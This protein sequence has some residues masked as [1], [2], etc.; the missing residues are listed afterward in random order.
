MYES[1]ETSVFAFPKLSDLNYGSWKTDMK[2]LLM[3]K[4]AGSLFL[5]LRNL[6]LKEHPI[7][8]SWRMNLESKA[9][10]RKPEENRQKQKNTTTISYGSGTV[11]DP[12]VRRNRKSSSNF[13]KYC[14]RK[15]RSEDGCF[16]KKEWQD[17][18]FCTENPGSNRLAAMK[19]FES[20]NV[21]TVVTRERPVEFLIGSAATTHICN[22][23]DWFSNLKEVY[24][25]EVLVGERDSSAKAVGIGD[26][27]FTILDIKGKVEINSK[28]VFYVPK[29][30]QNLICGAQIDIVELGILVG[31][32]LR[33]KGYRIFLP[34]EN[35][36]IETI[37]VYVDETKKGVRS[38][39]GK[40][41]QYEYAK[42]NLNSVNEFEDLDDSNHA[43]LLDKLSPFDIANWTR[44]EY[45]KTRSKRMHVYYCPP[46]SKIK[47]KSVNEVRKYC[48]E[49][50]I[51]FE[52]EFFFFKATTKYSD[53]NQSSE[54]DSS[55]EESCNSDEIYE[56]FE[57]EYYNSKLPKTFEDTQRS[58][59][60]EKW[61][62]AMREELN[63]MKTQK[64]FELVDPP[65]NKTIIGSKWVYNIKHEEKINQR[66]TKLV[67]LL[68]WNHVQLDVK[69]AYLYGKLNEKVYLKQQSGFIMKDAESKV[70]LLH[71][72]LYGL[73]QSG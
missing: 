28:N 13:C 71:K 25:T 54:N 63:M 34:N 8:N 31:Y 21:E 10:G 60:K 39:L 3:E 4:D 14:K 73:H 23:K 7:E 17:K 42:F 45:P 32:S 68:G 56:S 50:K 58:K 67:S 64:V 61:D 20:S 65:A 36:V 66:N 62:F 52:P 33:T 29:M 47:L 15:V 53:T 55:S 35:K 22:Q 9:G 48:K 6:D 38:L 40:N 1:T 72:A 43:K 41:K 16:K 57:Y 59:D 2:V 19:G 46:S 37:H 49:N 44:K 27:K 70:Y 24:P 5:E 11:L 30:R 18:S 26:I 69:S 12:G 51:T